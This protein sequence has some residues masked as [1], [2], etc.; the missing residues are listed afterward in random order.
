MDAGGG[1]GCGGTRAAGAKLSMLADLLRGLTRW[2]SPRAGARLGSR[3]D[4]GRLERARLLYEAGDMAAAQ[5]V[6]EA[7]LRDDE[8]NLEAGYYLGVILGRAG[9]YAQA[10][11][12][13]QQVVEQRPDFAD[14]LNALGNIEKMQEHWQAAEAYYRRA[15]V[16]SP[17][18]AA[19]WSN[20][21][22]CLR[23]AGRTDE[24][25]AALQSAL[26]IAPEFPDALET[27]QL[28]RRDF[29][30][31]GRR[32]RTEGLGYVGGC[33]GCNAAY[34]RAL[35]DGLAHPQ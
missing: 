22:L 6:Y 23:E 3:G 27:I 5:G 25:A 28:G 11:A 21:G 15:L 1:T 29:H 13:L 17:A 7:V 24:A 9:R 26:Q 34:I 19:I 16:V 33:C 31:F 20:L 18:V 32:A 30:E 4:G 14:A 10:R 2:L 8:G 35:A 12:H